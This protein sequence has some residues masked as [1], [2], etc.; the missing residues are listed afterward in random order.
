[1][2]T[3]VI[4]F[5]FNSHS[6]RTLAVNGS[7]WLVL[8]DVAPALGYSRSRNAARV[9]DD[10]EKGAHTVS[11]PGGDQT[12]TTINESGVYHLCFKSRRPEAKAFRKWVTA[13]VLPAIRKTGRYETPQ[14][15]T[16]TPAQQRHI[17]QVVNRLA[18]QPGNSHA[19]VY[20]SLKDKFMVGKYDQIPADQYPAA[21][22]Y[23]GVDPI[24]GEWLPAEE[25]FAAETLQDTVARLA[26]QVNKGN[27]Y[28]VEVFMPLV[29]AVLEKRGGLLPDKQWAD[30]SFRLERLGKLFH[31]FSEQAGDV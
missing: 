7:P 17:Q 16:L 4:P 24:E 2:N 8:D 12:M 22:H 19:A 18:Q 13:E 21:C 6:V 25:P 11:T 1:M 5:D 14:P 27:S 31:P 30:V 10:D 9:L 3:Q 23:L 29:N 20:R 28:P 26:S 15:E